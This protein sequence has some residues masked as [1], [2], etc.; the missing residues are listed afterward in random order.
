MSPSEEPRLSFL[1]PPRAN[2]PDLLEEFDQ[3]PID[4]QR[5]ATSDDVDY[6]H[7]TIVVADHLRESEIDPETLY[8]QCHDQLGFLCVVPP[9]PDS[10]DARDEI[11]AGLDITISDDAESDVHQPVA[12]FTSALTEKE[13][14]I[15]SVG[16]LIHTVGEVLLRTPAGEE[17]MV[18][19][20]SSN[21]EGSV[22]LTTANVLGRSL[23]TNAVHRE[24]L[25]TA[26]ADFGNARIEHLQTSPGRDQ[27]LK[28]D[29]Q[30]TDTPEP[31]ATALSSRQIDFGLLEVA[32]QLE[33]NNEVEFG[34]LGTRMPLEGAPDWSADEVSMFREWLVE[35]DALH[36]EAGI[37]RGRLL[38]LIE[39]RNLNSFRR[40]LT[41]DR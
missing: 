41:N 3:R 6:A 36:P 16:R 39:T 12:E 2:L 19:Y 23:R 30:S 20:R 37:D 40:R 28:S 24:A 29:K 5:P 7:P 10:D 26:V 21:I 34:S 33:T 22:V 31:S 18:E 17:T 15:A 1:R 32:L 4:I 14:T 35:R 9:F 38:K 25:L 8:Q 27:Q 13:L 11:A